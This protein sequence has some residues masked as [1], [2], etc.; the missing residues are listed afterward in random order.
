MK[1]VDNAGKCVYYSVWILRLM[2]GRKC[3]TLALTPA[4]LGRA[5]PTPN[6]TTP[7]R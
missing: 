4:K 5:H 2:N 7:A 1:I 3:S 6:D